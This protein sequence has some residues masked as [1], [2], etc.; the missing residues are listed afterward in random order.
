MSDAKNINS[1]E[2]PRACAFTGHRDIR[3]EHR[4]LV[5]DRLDRAIEY[6][7]SLGVRDFF[8]GGAL[9]FDTLA[10]RAV[11]AFRMSHTDVRLNLV[12]PCLNQDARW[13]E[14]QRDRYNFIL[15]NADSVEY[16]T[17]EYKNGCMMLRNRRL[18]ELADVLVAYVYRR[19]SGSSQTVRM[20]KELGR[21]VY[22]IS[23][24]VEVNM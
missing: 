19:G 17:D 21:T 22:N 12:L 10:A 14:A 5:E 13:S 2:A 23:P 4:A 20:A 1:N 18:A 7:Y 6:V 9:G 8:A 16:V 3:P 11:I 15:K 24:S